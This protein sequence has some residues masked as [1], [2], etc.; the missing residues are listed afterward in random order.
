MDKTTVRIEKEATEKEIRL[1]QMLANEM[2]PKDIASQWKVSHRTVEAYILTLKKTFGCKS[3]TGL[4][5]LFFRNKL[6]K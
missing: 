3:Y 4:V 6:I 1:V 2:R 5:T